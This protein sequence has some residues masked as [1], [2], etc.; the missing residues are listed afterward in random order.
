MKRLD[1]VRERQ[2]LLRLNDEESER[3]GALVRHY[4]LNAPNVLR[5]LIKK[6]SDALPP[7]P[8]PTAAKSVARGTGKS[9][10]AGK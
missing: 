8:A 1:R 10:R 7:P 3:L 2:V 9:G 5:L 6:E 4:G